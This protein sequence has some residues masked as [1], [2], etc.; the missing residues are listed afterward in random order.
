VSLSPKALAAAIVGITLAGTG[1]AT[2][3]TTSST[4]SGKTLVVDTSFQAGSADPA[5]DG[6]TTGRLVD[7]QLYQTLMLVDENDNTK[8]D[9]N[10]AESYS[11]SPD[12]LSY[13][14]KLRH[15]VHFSDGTPLTSADVVFSLM[16]LRNLKSG[17]SNFV[18]GLSATAPD[19][20]TVVISSAT[21]NPAIPFNVAIPVAGILNSKVVKA[22]GG[23]DAPNASSADKAEPFLNGVSAGSAPYVL[24]SLDP[25]SLIVLRANPN[26][27]GPKPVYAKI[28]FR[29]VPPSTQVLDVQTNPNTVALDLSP[30]QAATLDKSKANTL[31]RHS[32]EI[33][34]VAMNADPGVS[35]SAS[36]DFRQ[37]VR[38]GID[39]K[40]LLRLAGPGTA[41]A[42]GLLPTGVI[43]ALPANQL[44]SRDLAKAKAYLAS[45]GLQSPTISL[46]YPSDLSTSG[47]AYTDLA[48]QIQI[49]LKDVGIAVNLAPE[50][51]VVWKA[52]WKAHKI[53]MM[54]YSIG[55]NT[56]DPSAV[57][58]FGPGELEGNWMGWSKGMDPALDSLIAQIMAAPTNNERK[59]LLM[60]E[61]A[62]I[63]ADAVWVPLL[64][65][66]LVISASKDV[67]NLNLD[68][69]TEI[70]FWE[71]T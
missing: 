53:Q 13:T 59:P 60:Q 8:L 66:G 24:E 36:L 26:Y 21:P 16:R 18:A 9:P 33:F 35:V 22:H 3:S 1:C 47:I 70:R 10:I 71:M 61:Q 6:G 39:Y 46:E 37:A 62:A 54:V 56:F 41:Q 69:L 15:D 25:Q 19:A 45:S 43:G 68:G 28:Q 7:Q 44:I 32:L 40:A 31:T 4:N 51:F 34:V 5:T 63:N 42:Q 17:V 58:L 67:G 48:Q 14:Y 30:A 29:N 49:N 11:V 64:Q 50:P 12:G 57:F 52:R 65:A 2:G 27:W 55:G 38:Y 20:Y 23:T